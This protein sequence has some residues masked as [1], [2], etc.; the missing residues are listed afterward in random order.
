MALEVGGLVRVKAN[1]PTGRIAAANGH[2]CKVVGQWFHADEVENLNI[3]ISLNNVAGEHLATLSVSPDM[4]VG[5]FV[6]ETRKACPGKYVKSLLFSDGLHADDHIVEVSLS[7]VT[8]IFGVLE[9]EIRW[10]V[11]YVSDISVTVAAQPESL[12]YQ[13]HAH[14]PRPSLVETQSIQV[15]G[16]SHLLKGL[17][18]PIAHGASKRQDPLTLAEME[19]LNNLCSMLEHATECKHFTFS[20]EAEDDDTPPNHTGWVAHVAG[21]TIEVAYHHAW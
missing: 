3:C 2:A 7:P 16:T 8:V 20:S 19:Q 9:F 1:G 13:H 11:G 4:S 18:E 15:S 14:W 21:H 12:F 6:S 10:R 17:E 5:E